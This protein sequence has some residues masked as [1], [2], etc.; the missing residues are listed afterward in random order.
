MAIGLVYDEA[1]AWPLLPRTVEDAA[2]FAAV[3]EGVDFEVTSCAIPTAAAPDIMAEVSAWARGANSGD[4]AVVYL[5]GHGKIEDYGNH[6]TAACPSP[7]DGL[8]PTN[9]I[10]SDALW[11]TVARAGDLKI[12]VILDVCHSGFGANEILSKLFESANRTEGPPVQ[13]SVMAACLPFQDAVDGVFMKSLLR[14]L[15]VG[16]ELRHWS[17][18]DRFIHPD[19]LAEELNH[20]LPGQRVTNGGRG[21]HQILPNPRFLPDLPDL[22]AADDARIQALPASDRQRLLT[23]TAPGMNLQLY[24]FAAQR[25]VMASLVEARSSVE[26]GLFVVTG[27]PGAG[28]S[29]LLGQLATRGLESGVE[30]PATRAS[31]PSSPLDAVDAPAFGAVVSASR[32]RLTEL[33][34]AIA[35]SLGI[36]L[37]GRATP[38]ALVEAIGGAPAAVSVLI[39]GLNEMVGN[40]APTAAQRLVRRIAECPNAFVVVGTRRVVDALAVDQPSLIDLMQPSP[41]VPFA[42]WDLDEPNEWRSDLSEHVLA[43]GPV[44]AAPQAERAA[45]AELIA[46]RADGNFLV[47]DLAIREVEDRPPNWEVGWRDE[48]RTRLAVSLDELISRDLGRLDVDFTMAIELLRPLAFAEGRGLPVRNVWPLFARALSSGDRV[49][50]QVDVADL[51]DAA[52]WYLVASTIGD[53]AVYRLRHPLLVDYFRREAAADAQ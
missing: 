7:L 5:A 43:A 3:L 19:A 2:A 31:N 48:L 51:I 9:A 40:D 30:V 44:L 28:K 23:G 32:L 29:V 15:E 20:R 36:G 12:L 14:A 41:G 52:A 6:F 25:T 46:T 18:R 11:K 8:D 42:I 21:G 47:A 33:V 16:S 45:L 24:L 38:E 50:S 35:T 27:S 53:E 34:E 17:D 10:G 49:Y 1:S 22:V 4:V 39:D 26:S 37:L 13:L